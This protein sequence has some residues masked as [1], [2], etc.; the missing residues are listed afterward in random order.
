[1]TVTSVASASVMIHVAK[2]SAHIALKVEVKR[3]CAQ[4]ADG[5][6][7]PIAQSSLR[8]RADCSGTSMFAGYFQQV[9]KLHGLAGWLRS[10]MYE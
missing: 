3:K 6:Q 9:Y 1:M 4:V 10:Y 5:M 7:T 8:I 2:S